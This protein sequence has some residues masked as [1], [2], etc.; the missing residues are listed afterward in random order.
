MC[1]ITWDEDKKHLFIENEDGECKRLD[2][3]LIEMYHGNRRSERDYSKQ[4]K[5]EVECILQSME[6]GKC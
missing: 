6:P 2:R 1:R 5:E 3:V 4:I